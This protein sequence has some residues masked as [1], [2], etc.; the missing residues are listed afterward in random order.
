M[1]D[2]ALA[3]PSNVAH[4]SKEQLAKQIFSRGKKLFSELAPHGLIFI[5]LLMSGFAMWSA[6]TTA[7]IGARAIASTE[8]SD[9][10]AL[11]A[12]AVAAAES[13]E[14]KYRLEPGPDVR[15]RYNAVS[16]ELTT[17][18]DRIYLT[19]APGDRALVETVRALQ[20][21]YLESIERMFGAVDRGQ[22]TEVLRIDNDEVDPRFEK[23]EK[24]VDT[25]SDQHQKDTVTALKDLRTRELFNA[26]AIPIVFFVGM[27]FAVLFSKALQRTRKLLEAHSR[28]ALHASQHDALT[29]LPNR[30][31][32]H[33]RFSQALRLGRRNNTATGLLLIDLDRF[34]QVNDTLG[35]HY[36]DLLLIQV[37][38]RLVSA[39]REGDTVARLGGD[40]F[41]IL[42]PV[43]VDLAEAVATAHRLREAMTS[44]FNIE[45]VD[46][47][48]E[49]SFG[50]VVSGIHGEDPSDLMQRADIAMYGAKKN[51]K[52]VQVYNPEKDRRTPERLAMLSE[53]RNAIAKEELFLQYQP[54]ICLA[55]GKVTGVE[56]LVR[57]KHPVR[58]LVPPDDFIPFAEHTGIIGPLTYYILKRAL[59]QVRGWV[60]TGLHMPVS[61]NISARNLSDTNLVSQVKKL[62]TRYDLPPN[63]LVLE[64]T[65]SAIML[66]SG[67]ARTALT[68]LHNMGVC[69]SIDDFGAGYTSLSQLKNL[70][71]SELKI[72]KSFILSMQADPANA[73]IVRSVVALG[74]NLGMKVV[75]EGVET[76]I[77]M[78]ELGGYQCDIAQGY[79]LCRPINGDAFRQ[80]YVERESATLQT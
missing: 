51:A 12:R 68:D 72:D 71:I 19:G 29:Q 8:L 10:Y 31:L 74:H 76:A 53:L 43:V 52:G 58:G 41:A 39:L 11:A 65:E 44:A 49:A 40:E 63:L 25:A 23:I 48:V 60:E 18:L 79:H 75:A 5:L 62:L 28:D 6:I 54:K 36:G 9:Y 27:F 32:L 26:K 15:A 70:P 7:R 78:D 2:P 37:A 61:V 56:A 4:P 13:L 57:W 42:L 67:I 20:V 38:S 17:S 34:K 22:I 59:V 45:E 47:D 30:I 69:I 77:V 35:H 21:P 1:D 14:R 46:L 80:W 24:T 66:D 50:V 16:K 33:E 3:T 73:L 55:T 64:V